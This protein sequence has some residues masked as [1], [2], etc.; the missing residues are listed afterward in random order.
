MSIYFYLQTVTGTALLCVLRMQKIKRHK[1][2]GTYQISAK[3]IKAG[4]KT[5]RS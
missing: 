5:V 4:G 3:L 2:P 1:S